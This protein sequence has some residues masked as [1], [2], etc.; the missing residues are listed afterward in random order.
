MKRAALDYINPILEKINL[1]YYFS[2]CVNSYPNARESFEK[3]LFSE[4]ISEVE[5]NLYL[6]AWMKAGVSFNQRDKV[7]KAFHDYVVTIS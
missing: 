4:A 1:P 2:D 5:R 6:T 7:T 3:M